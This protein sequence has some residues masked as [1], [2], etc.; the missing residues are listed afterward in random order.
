M[1]TVPQ[2]QFLVLFLEDFIT[3]GPA[4][5]KKIFD[6]L[7]VEGLILDELSHENER[8][9]VRSHMLEWLLTPPEWIVEAAF[10]AKIWLNIEQFFVGD[11]LIRLRRSVN[12][13]RETD[14]DISPEMAGIL[15]RSFESEIALVE[16]LTGRNLPHWRA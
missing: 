12:S 4:Q 11:A 16:R 7:G 1:Q 2:D 9:A 14:K 15:A 5:F 6:F 3:D 10:G 13:V 8:R